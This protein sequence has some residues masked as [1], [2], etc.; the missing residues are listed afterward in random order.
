LRETDSREFFR[1][2][3][4]RQSNGSTSDSDREGMG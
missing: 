4:I 1:S 3:H 2:A